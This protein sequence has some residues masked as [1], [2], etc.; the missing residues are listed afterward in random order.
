MG[1]SETRP[2]TFADPGRFEIYCHHSPPT[3]YPEET[4]ETVQVC[5]PLEGALYQVIRSS[6]TGRSLLHTLG[7]RDVL[8][9]P[10]GQPHAVTWR[11]P[12][13]VV[14]LQLSGRFISQA[15]GLSNL[16]LPDTFTVR[17]TFVSAAAAQ[18]RTVL[19]AEGGVSPAFAEAMATAIAYRVAVAGPTNGGRIGGTDRGAALSKQQLTRIEGF[20]DEHLDEPIPVTRLAELLGMSTWHFMRRFHASH[21]TSPHAFITQRRVERAQ[22]LLANP[23][24]SITAIALEVGL[25]HS[26]FSRAF[27]AN[28]GVSPREY[29]RQRLS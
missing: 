9:V 29:R 22:A 10:A 15:L 25:S 6:E 7:S 8:V 2:L 12:A 20:I 14:S 23:T 4:H 13:D 28:V 11:R 3:I 21:G 5:V 16:S 18:L 27:L 17:D 1:I 24:L 26:H 19:R